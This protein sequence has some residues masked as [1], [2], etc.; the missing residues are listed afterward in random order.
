MEPYWSRIPD[1][2]DVHTHLF[3][4]T[5]CILRLMDRHGVE[6]SIVLAMGM[7]NPEVLKYNESICFKHARNHPERIAAMVT[8]DLSGIDEQDYAVREME[9]LERSKDAGAVGVKVS[10]ELG[11]FA[12]DCAGNLIVV[13]DSRL[14]PVWDKAG[15]LRMPVLIHIGD[16]PAYWRHVDEN[17][18]WRVLLGEMPGWVYHGR[19]NFPGFDE[20][21]QKRNNILRTHP[22]TTFI[23]AHLGSDAWDME[24]A[25]VMANLDAFPNFHV[26]ASAVVDEIGRHP[27]N[28]RELFMKYADRIMHGT[29]LIVLSAWDSPAEIARWAD[30]MG[31]YNSTIFRFYETPDDDISPT[32]PR[33]RSWKIKGIDLPDDVLRKIYYENARRIIPGL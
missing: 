19:E 16:P 11:L 9:H 17:N 1:K 31:R 6:K 23:G 27:E 26:D 33:L 12:R 32:E 28:T 10:K 13:D 15:E 25:D 8:F 22:N 29:D 2:I 4:D 5:D 30:E 7:G 24:V 21:M 18:P 14:D 20:L 3:A